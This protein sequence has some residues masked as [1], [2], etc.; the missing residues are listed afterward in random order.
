MRMLPSVLGLVVC[1]GAVASATITVV[2]PTGASASDSFYQ[3]AANAINGSGLSADVVTGASVPTPWPTHGV[4]QNTMW[5]ASV[6]VVNIT[7]DLGGPYP[8]SGFHLWNENEALGVPSRRG[9]SQ[10][11]LSASL[12][13]IAGSF[14]PVSFLPTPLV[15]A[16]GNATYVGDDYTLATLVTARY[17]RFDI[18]SAI[19]DSLTGLAEIRFI[20]DDTPI[21]EPS[22]GLLVILAAGAVCARRR[23]TK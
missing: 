16:P 5:L 12:T 2:K 4:A 13:G 3:A 11:V 7:F 17:F 14:T 15:G 19:S 23:R 21:P 9:A 22:A 8:I 18:S 6:Q 1:L 20:S 10:A